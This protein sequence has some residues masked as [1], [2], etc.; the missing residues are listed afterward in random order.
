MSLPF[1]PS[2]RGVRRCIGSGL[3]LVLVLLTGCVTQPP[4]FK[5]TADAGTRIATARRIA[6]VKP[7]VIVNQISAGGV[8]EKHDQW[9][10]TAGQNL[11]QAAS[12]ET[13]FS[14]AP[15]TLGDPAAQS[16]LV[17]VRAL[18]NTIVQNHLVFL[19][20]PDPLS[21]ARRP[22]TY[23]VGRIDRIA[24]ACDADAL[25]FIIASD[26]R[27]TGG[28]KALELLGFAPPTATF[29]SAMLVDRDGT[30][31]WFNYMISERI[32]IRDSDG[33]AEVMKTLLTGL[34]RN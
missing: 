12:R 27:A 2:A 31:L 7:D 13:G 6:I 18:V 25:L 9:S 10:E 22:L 14:V 28:R 3:C 23:N 20:A 11:S 19:Y 1:I 8:V 24:D 5:L 32:D 30:V 34:P 21:T 29:A 17:D 16:E 26:S 33:A 15:S 4:T